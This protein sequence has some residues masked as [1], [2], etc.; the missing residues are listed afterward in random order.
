MAHASSTNPQPDCG[1]TPQRQQRVRRLRTRCSVY[2]TRYFIRWLGSSGQRARTRYVS[3][4]LP[5]PSQTKWVKRICPNYSICC[6]SL[7]SLRFLQ[8]TILIILPG[9]SELWSRSRLG[10]QFGEKIWYYI[11][12]YFTTLC[13]W[14][15]KYHEFVRLHKYK[16]QLNYCI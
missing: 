6:M 1:N 3:T 13:I 4:S 11:Y 16:K 14:Q 15:Y 9:F 8:Q 7:N 5:S 12:H 2:D 10:C